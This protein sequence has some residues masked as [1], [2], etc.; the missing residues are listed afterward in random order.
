M[1]LNRFHNPQAQ[2]QFD[3]TVNKQRMKRLHFLLEKSSA[4]ATILGQKLAK[5]QEE[6]RERVAPQP[7]PASST[8][9]TTSTKRGGNKARATSRKRKTTDSNYQLTDYLNEDVRSKITLKYCS[10]TKYSFIFPL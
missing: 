10:F 2:A 8:T 3:S 5:Q 6:A 1:I 4:Y 9:T 7:T